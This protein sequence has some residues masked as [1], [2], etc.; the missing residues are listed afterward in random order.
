MPQLVPDFLGM[1]KILSSH[2][3]DFILVG[4]VAAVLH[5]APLH[6]YDLDI[7]HSRS[8]ENLNR[9]VAALSELGAYYRFHPNKI[10]P[11]LSQLASTGH[12]LLVTK[13]GPLDVLGTIGKDVG[14]EDLLSDSHEVHVEVGLTVRLLNLDKLIEIKEQTGRAKDHAALPVLRETLR[15]SAKLQTDVQQTEGLTP[16]EPPASDAS[17]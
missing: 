17:D 10:G 2:K 16:P 14:Y 12:Q 15:E 13:M 4:G 6:T 7:V 11:T 1:V 8:A 3:V 5:G 9:L